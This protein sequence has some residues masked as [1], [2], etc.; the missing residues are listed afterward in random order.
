M[1]S[2]KIVHFTS[3][4]LKDGTSPV[5]LRV[6]INRKPKYYKIGSNY[7][8]YPGQWNK[9][10][11]KFK[12]NIG[13]P[14][15]ANQKLL[16]TLNKAHRIILDLESEKPDFNH[17]DF[18]KIFDRKNTKLY[19]F[20]YFDEIIK[21]LEDQNKIGNADTYKDSKRA[22]K[23]FLKEDIE[24]KEL[25]V[26]DLNL[27][28]EDCFKRDLKGTT[29]SIWMRTLRALYNKAIKEEGLE[30][31]PF[32]NYAWKR[33]N[34]ETEKRA[35]SK[36]DIMK[37]YNYNINPDHPLYDAKQFFI[38]SYLTYG[39]NFADLAK[40]TAENIVQKDNIYILSYNRSKGG[41]HFDI[42][43]DKICVG[44]IKFYQE[45][46]PKS[47]YIFPILDENTHDTPPKI[48][49]RIKKARK[50]YNQELKKLA[51]DLGINEH[52]TSYV[53][54]HSFASIMRSEGIKDNVISEMMGHTT[55]NTT[56]TYLK[57]F[58]YKTK[59]NAGKKLL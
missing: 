7:Y 18:K 4:K 23:K 58:D 37:I 17:E 27:F 46:N 1:A 55:E 54:R 2:V 19:L 14:G 31:Y 12:K 53:A 43:L 39:I 8:C 3:K 59:L 33:L 24:M 42:P 10:E 47:K 20:Q 11:G 56:K 26:K 6:T 9:E 48:K 34:L 16:D 51:E 13:N 36:E 15:K 50:R 21:R 29:I 35:I 25:T 57:N 52:L 32:K 49:N 41:K 5:L 30:H 40:L 45:L 44:I 22:L 28:T 38:F